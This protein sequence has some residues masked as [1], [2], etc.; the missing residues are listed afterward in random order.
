MPPGGSAA[1]HAVVA[2][3]C[4]CDRQYKLLDYIHVNEVVRWW[5]A[6]KSTKAPKYASYMTWI[7]AC[8]LKLP[9]KEY[10]AQHAWYGRWL[11]LNDTSVNYANFYTTLWGMKKPVL[12]LSD[13]II[14]VMDASWNV[15]ALLSP[16][17]YSADSL[18]FWLPVLPARSSLYIDVYWQ[19]NPPPGWAIP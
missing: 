7:K 9:E 15:S 16:V 2:T 6:A 11:C 10:F 5:R 3:Y 12:S 4:D 14:C 1:R 17:A 8:C 13:C 19:L 18:S